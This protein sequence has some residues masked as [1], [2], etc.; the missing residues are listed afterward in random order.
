MMYTAES[1]HFENVGFRFRICYV[2]QLPYVLSK[3]NGW[4][5]KILKIICD[6]LYYF[7]G[8]ILN[9]VCHEIFELYFFMIVTHLGPW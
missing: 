5:K 8:N 4:S 9:G 2:L 6:S 3:E 7:H 1:D